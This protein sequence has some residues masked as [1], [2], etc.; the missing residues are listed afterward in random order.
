MNTEKVGFIGLGNMGHPMAKNLE[1]AGFPLIVYNRNSSK[2]D[3]FKIKS[4]VASTVKELVKESDIIFTMLTN[5]E[6]VKDVYMQILEL[7][8][9]D[10]LFIDMSTIS[11][12]RKRYCTVTD[13]KF[14]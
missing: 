13:F 9:A 3:D 1:K 14:T 6:A 12:H 10:K 8:I 2:T 5:D 4:K 11:S 7:N